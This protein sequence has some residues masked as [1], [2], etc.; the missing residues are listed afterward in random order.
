MESKIKKT[1]TKQKA[2]L[3]PASQKIR[4]SKSGP[5]VGTTSK[6]ANSVLK[7]PTGA[8]KTLDYNFSVG[9]FP[10]KQKVDDP[11]TKVQPKRTLLTNPSL[12]SL[13]SQ[14]SGQ[15]MITSAFF[16]KSP[17]GSAAAE[18]QNPARSVTS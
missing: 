17:K 7:P 1:V 15:T 11:I 3:V 2:Q 13:K 8:K 12:Q 6:P 14:P 10:L 18:A 4:V 16:I 9:T 5:R